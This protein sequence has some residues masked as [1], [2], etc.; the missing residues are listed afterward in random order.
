MKREKKLLI[1]SGVLVVC[2]AGAVV[3]SRI[4]FEEKMTGTETAIVDVDSSEITYLAWNYENND[5]AFT[6]QDGTWA[7]DSDDKMPVDQE[8][9]NE[10]AENLSSITSDKQALTFGNHDIQIF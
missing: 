1:L 2:V 10:I 3:I 4:D 8:L 7:Y 5:V 6:C 9:L